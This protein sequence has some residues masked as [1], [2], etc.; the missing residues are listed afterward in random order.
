MK[1]YIYHYLLKIKTNYLLSSP[2]HCTLLQL[3]HRYIAGQYF[4]A[5]ITIHIR[6]I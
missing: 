6:F 3:P 2:F 5:E 4:A 1:E